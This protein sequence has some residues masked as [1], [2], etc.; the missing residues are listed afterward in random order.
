VTLTAPNRWVPAYATAN[1][2]RRK[3]GVGCIRR[4]VPTTRIWLPGID[5][6]TPSASDYSLDS[7]QNRWVLPIPLQRWNGSKREPLDRFAVDPWRCLSAFVA[8]RW[9]RHAGQIE[10]VSSVGEAKEYA[11]DLNP[12]I[13]RRR[14]GAQIHG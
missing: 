10:I 13:V 14:Q 1:R 8:N 3:A 6:A 9:A 4:V 5:S 7:L 12:V 11:T 2:E